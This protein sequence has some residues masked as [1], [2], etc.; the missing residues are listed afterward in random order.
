MNARRFAIVTLT[1]VLI[2]ALFTGAVSALGGNAAPAVRTQLANVRDFSS[3]NAISD[4]YAVDGGVLFQGQP[5]AWTQVSTPEDVI[6]SAVAVNSNDTNAVYIGAANEMAIFRTLDNGR[7]WLRIPLTEKYIG[8]VT[9]IAI[10]GAQSIVY[11]GTDTAGLF[12]LRDIGS[13]VVLGGHLLLEEPVLEVVAD[14]TGKGMAFARTAWNLYRAEDFGLAWVAV[15]NLQSTA[16]AVAIANTDPAQVY[17]GTMDRGLLVSN[18]GLEWTM[19]NQGLNFVPGSRLMIS[20]LAIDPAQPEV[21]YV[22]TSY[23]YGTNEVHTAPGG[24]ALSTDGAEAWSPIYEASNLAVAELLPVSG[25]TGGV[26]ALTNE[27]RTPLALGNAPMITEVAVA[28]QPVAETGISLTTILAW[29]IAGLAALALI[30]AVAMDLRSR[31]TEE[32]STLTPSPV[33]TR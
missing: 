31:R 12:R 1:I 8:G 6:V 10:D 23:L 16:T 33:R 25:V 19:A 13:S 24:V 5:G 11:V 18:N 4:S 32:E 20:D 9:D 17:V 3:V 21:M 26:Y 30:F 2:L 15:N 29:V 28:T 14:S 7:S 27:S 22:A